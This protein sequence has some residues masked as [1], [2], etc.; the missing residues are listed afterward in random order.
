MTKIEML[1]TQNKQMLLFKRALSW[2]TGCKDDDDGF[3]VFF[4]KG[5]G[6]RVSSFLRKVCA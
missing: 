5:G 3:F 1:L 2:S 4:L 6:K